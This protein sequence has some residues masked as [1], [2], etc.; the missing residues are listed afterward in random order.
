MK[1]M[2]FPLLVLMLVAACAITQP[3]PTSTP[4]PPTEPLPTPLPEPTNTP[5]PPKPTK[6]PLSP[7][8]FEVLF[9]GTDCTVDGPT[10]LPSGDYAFTFIDESDWR[11]EVYLTYIDDDKNLQDQLD[12]QSEPGDWYPKPS[13]AHYDVDV[14]PW[15]DLPEDE[16]SEGRKVTTS[17]WRLKKVAEHI[18]LCYVPSPAK[19]WFA[20]PIWII[21]TSTD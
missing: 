9:D 15:Y 11:G 7:P 20:A 19:I 18:I 1:N 4:V 2:V 16:V 5:R 17:V 14:S 6:T 12:L 13:W 21:D 3:A 8:L 10:E